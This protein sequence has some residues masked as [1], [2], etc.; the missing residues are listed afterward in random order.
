MSLSQSKAVFD[1]VV[2]RLGV[3]PLPELLESLLREIASLLRVER[4]GYW[5]LQP[6]HS[7]IDRQMQFL[8]STG[9]FDL[10]PQA[11]LA[12][13]FPGYFNALKE[14]N[15]IVSHD[16]MADPQLAEFR[17]VYFKPH[18]ISSMLDVPVHR[19]GQLFGVICHEHVGPARRWADDEVE[20]ARSLTHLVALAIETDLRQRAEE[21]LKNA[22]ERE[23][24]LVEMKTNFVSLVSHEFRTPLGVIVSSS[25]ILENY[26]D[27]LK[28]DQRA[29]HL[30]DIR[31]SAQQMS[32]LMEEVL[33]LGK[34]ESGRMSCRCDPISLA[35]CCNRI[36]DEQHSA[37]NG[38]CPIRLELNGVD[39]EAH[40]DEGLLRHILNN[41]LSNAVKYSPAGQAVRFAVRRDRTFAEFEIA[42][43]GIGIDPAD[44][45]HLF[46]AFYRG[47]NV[48]DTPG[49]GL[50]LVI[51]K[52]CVDL[53]DGTLTFESRPGDGSRFVV[54]LKMFSGN[55]RQAK[56]ASPRK[57]PIRSP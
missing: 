49:T 6:D 11:L 45:K 25:D 22:L 7:A 10:S 9:Q 56:S 46:T 43:R 15:L 39:A 26:F 20:L 54:R 18:G 52:R 21:E 4:V 30:Q 37:T 48:G 27:R 24:E 47:N 17:D 12:R 41:L 36:V 1:R 19:N 31:H 38:K 28:P 42:D 51:V 55:G 3:T 33:L 35:D 5:K 40:G 2:T 57:R 13:D 14:S 32:A 29:A 23:K 16:V 53:H 44:Q 8:R 34:V 50:G